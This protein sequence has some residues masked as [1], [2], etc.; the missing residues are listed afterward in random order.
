MLTY[1]DLGRVANNEGFSA[2]A[3]GAIAAAVIGGLLVG[4]AGTFLFIKRP[5]LPNIPI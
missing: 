1:G 3:K 4:G 5:A 2:D